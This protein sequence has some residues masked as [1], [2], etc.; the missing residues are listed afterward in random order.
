MIETEYL[1]GI[2]QCVSVRVNQRIKT[3]RRQILK[4][5]LQGTGLGNCESWLGKCEIC[6]ADCRRGWHELQLQFPGEI[7]PTVLLVHSPRLLRISSLLKTS[8]YGP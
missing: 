5:L 1:I 6:R 8:N 3:N 7:S 2:Y 4:D